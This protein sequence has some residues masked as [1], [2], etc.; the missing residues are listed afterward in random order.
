MIV[1]I[2]SR[3]DELGD[4]IDG[5]IDDAELAMMLHEIEP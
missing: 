4:L 5:T 3:L 2:I 1:D